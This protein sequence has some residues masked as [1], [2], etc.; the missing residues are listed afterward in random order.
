MNRQP[1]FAE[2]RGEQ[3]KGAFLRLSG[4]QPHKNEYPK[5]ENKLS[6]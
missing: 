6:S 3:P 2:E 4:G 1:K 5:I